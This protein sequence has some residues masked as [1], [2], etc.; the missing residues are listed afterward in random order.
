[1]GHITHRLGKEMSQV[2]PLIE[3]ISTIIDLKARPEDVPT[4]NFCNLAK[5]LY[6]HDII[7]LPLI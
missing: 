7:K 4:E 6:K 1:M 5:L 2:Q 3:E